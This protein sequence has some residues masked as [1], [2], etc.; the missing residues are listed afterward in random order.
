MDLVLSLDKRPGSD[1]L[2]KSP[3]SHRIRRRLEKPFSNNL[4]SQFSSPVGLSTI[5]L[6]SPLGWRSVWLTG[7]PV[8]SAWQDAHTRR[9]CIWQSCSSGPER[10]RENSYVS[11]TN[12]AKPGGEKT[13][14]KATVLILPK[15]KTAV[16]EGNVGYSSVAR[17]LYGSLPPAWFLSR[18]SVFMREKEKPGRVYLREEQRG[19]R[20]KGRSTKKEEQAILQEKYSQGS[21]IKQPQRTTWK[22]NLE[23]GDGDPSK[24]LGG[25]EYDS[26]LILKKLGQLT[27][28][29]KKGLRQSEANCRSIQLK[30][31]WFGWLSAKMKI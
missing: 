28:K 16:S 7:T 13:I 1:K 8:A 5:A 19:G 23:L 18:G 11:A 31:I 9:A 27:K 26:S 14:N 20:V 15:W 10:L 12:K 22:N 3:L 29:K 4:I 2:Q 17:R 24:D 25:I 6:I 30:C 21:R